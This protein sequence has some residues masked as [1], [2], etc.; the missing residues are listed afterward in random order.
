MGL[1]DVSVDNFDFVILLNQDPASVCVNAE[2]PWNTLDELLDD[3]KQN[4]GKYMFSASSTGGIWDLSRIG[5]LN[6]A[7]IPVDS[8]IWVPTV[9]LHLHI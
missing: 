7:G 3:I 5:M 4:P 9:V 6:A 8:V 2:S 1:T